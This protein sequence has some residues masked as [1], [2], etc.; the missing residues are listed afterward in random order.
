M[1]TITKN[2]RNNR[3]ERLILA[4]LAGNLK[5]IKKMTSNESIC[6]PNGIEISATQNNDVLV[7]H[8]D[9]RLWH[10]YRYELAADRPDSYEKYHSAYRL[11][12]TII[13]AP[14]DP[15][16]RLKVQTDEASSFV[17]LYEESIQ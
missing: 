10:Q 15:A 4:E 8:I 2:S 6:L 9:L 1:P 3:I 5:I 13:D 14:Q 17:A 12:E 16:M 7:T 11:A